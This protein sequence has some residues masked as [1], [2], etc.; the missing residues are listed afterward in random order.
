MSFALFVAGVT[1]Q[2]LVDALMQRRFLDFQ[3]TGDI[4]L[5]EIYLALVSDIGQ[6][7]AGVLAAVVVVALLLRFGK[8]RSGKVSEQ[9]RRYNC[10][11]AP[12]AWG[13]S[14][15]SVDSRAQQLLADRAARR[16]IRPVE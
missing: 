12:L 15:N 3:F 7:L 4:R 8:D 13:S 14:D 9:R 5:N 10:V 11:S 6:L 1:M 2:N 16:A